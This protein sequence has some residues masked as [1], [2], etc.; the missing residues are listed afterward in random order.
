[1]AT[2]TPSSVYSKYEINQEDVL[3][4]LL[5]LPAVMDAVGDQV[6]LRKTCVNVYGNKWRVNLWVSINNPVVPNAGRI[7]KS[8]FVHCSNL[9]FELLE[10]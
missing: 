1:M 10:D 8:Y 5:A 9:S 2:I 7:L 4:S 3:A 6:L